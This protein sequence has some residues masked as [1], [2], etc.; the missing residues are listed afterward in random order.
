[1]AKMS[2]SIAS[3][4]TC[5]PVENTL[6]FWGEKFGYEM[7]VNFSPYGQI[8][9]ELLT[10]DSTLNHPENDVRVLF[11]RFEDWIRNFQNEE[12]VSLQ[13][14]V[15]DNIHNLSEYA[16]TSAAY[17]KSSLFLTIAKNSPNS[18]IKAD[19]QREFEQLLYRL[20]SDESNIFV[21]TPGEIHKNYPVH[22]FYD[23]QRDQLGHIP[24]KSEYFTAL[25]TSVFRNVLASKRKPYKVIVM[26]CDNT[27][28][29]GVCGE[30][31]PKGI[32]L[33]EPYI[34][35]QLFMLQQI[36]F[37]KILCLC[38]KNAEEDVDNVFTERTDMILRKEDI[39]SSKI[40]WQSKSQNIRELSEELNLGLDS[41]I[42]VDD[43]PVECAEV[44]SNCPE[45]L[46]LNLPEQPEEITSFLN[47]VWTFDALKSTQEDQ[48]RTE[49][50]KENIKRSSFRKGSSTLKNFIEGLNLEISIKEMAEDEISRVSQLTYRTNQFNF[51]TIRRSE[52]EIKEL[53]LT[54]GFSCKVCRVKDRFGDYGL[55]GVMLY[56]KLLNRIVLD[57][58]MLSC[59]VL[60]RGVEHK[61]L[62]AVGEAALADEIDTVEVN[63]RLTE[64]NLPALNFLQSIVEDFPSDI[65]PVNNGYSIASSCLSELIYNPDKNTG[66]KTPGN[67]QT[68][69][70]VTKKEE[71]NHLIFEQIANELNAAFKIQKQLHSNEHTN[72]NKPAVSL[73][74]AKNGTLQI[75]TEI[76]ENVLEKTGIGTDRHFFD[77]GGT[78]LKAV[79]VLSQLNERFNKNL[80]IVSLFEHSTIQSLVK[81]VEN[82]RPERSEFNKIIQRAELRRNRLIR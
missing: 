74:P 72:D 31:G 61:M 6:R 21:I 30:V 58:F 55:V 25:A 24:F 29:G 56:Q 4:F 9:Q 78:S 26:D 35:L 80:S 82:E 59:R 64:K 70:S 81:L 17:T 15:L 32:R 11:I 45:V 44:R 62:R 12:E 14:H 49:L 53:L 67:G 79:E 52:V 27:L 1:M 73:P 18:L 75:I 66:V 77:V 50:Y 23:P 37:G 71:G 69:K 33:S 2:I 60:G 38:S 43:N 46:T 7:S 22:D 13:A 28:W 36:R 40:N 3:T 19:Q 48:K 39:V 42:F 41:F 57:S 47:H 16:R 54:K 76:W 10:L 68:T 65:Q 20:L 8:F 51:T 5:D 34:N 63:F